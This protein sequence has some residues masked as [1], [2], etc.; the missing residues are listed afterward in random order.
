MRGPDA[1]AYRP[2][3]DAWL[4]RGA[5]H[6]GAY[7]RATEIFS[8]GKFLAEPGEGLGADDVAPRRRRWPAA[9]VLAAAAVAVVLTFWLTATNT[10]LLRLAGSSEIARMRDKNQAHPILLSTGAES[11]KS[12][13]L[14]D[15]STLTLDRDSVLSVH[16]SR[17]MRALRLTRGRGRF[18]VAHESRPFIVYAGR[19]SVTARG[20]L[21]DVAIDPRQHVS[22]RLLRGAVDVALPQ[23][24]RAVR[25]LTP[26]QEVSFT[27]TAMSAST[28]A[29][30]ADHATAGLG[31]ED[32]DRV[33]LSDLLA[34][35]N[36]RGGRPIRVADPVLGTIRVSGRFSLAN[37]A[38]LA[39]H[40]AAVQNLVVD[41]SDPEQIT[42]RRQ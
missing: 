14:A 38:K 8:M 40:L 2:D 25:H 29:V 27:M 41:T 22:V 16:Y 11:G 30:V 4:A 3:F 21:F 1:A 36:R 34:N 9:L 35:A 24:V 31:I 32:F 20:T 7:N 13:A 42:L 12:F 17:S 19:G 15:G 33:A 23:Q 28:S 26:G 10:T 39:D 37:P 18:D 5:A 6:L